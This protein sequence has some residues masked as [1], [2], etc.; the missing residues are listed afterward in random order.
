[1]EKMLA[2]CDYKTKYSKTRNPFKK[3]FYKIRLD[4]E[5]TELEDIMYRSDLYN[6]FYDFCTRFVDVP[7]TDNIFVSSIVK[8]NYVMCITQDDCEAK[9]IIR[10]NSN[11]EEGFDLT[12]I[13]YND[14][15]PPYNMIIKV[16]IEEIYWKYKNKYLVQLN[17][18][19]RISIHQYIIN[20]LYK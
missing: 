13:P 18:N 7:K 16:P 8:D 9:F 6:L 17:T 19:V 11:K 15:D 4:L 1:M 20:F 10:I 5:I 3:L 12:V 2:I 14:L